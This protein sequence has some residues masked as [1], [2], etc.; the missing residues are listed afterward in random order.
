MRRNDYAIWYFALSPEDTSC[1]VSGYVFDFP[2]LWKI[3]TL[4]GPITIL[5]GNT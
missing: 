1:I 2:I 4:F 3:Q 5:P